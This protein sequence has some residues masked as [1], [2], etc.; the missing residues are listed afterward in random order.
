MGVVTNHQHDISKTTPE[1]VNKVER[2][3]TGEE[4]ISAGTLFTNENQ[5]QTQTSQTQMINQGS[6]KSV[7]TSITK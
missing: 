2:L 7:T 6:S 4:S 5:T 3:F 1:E